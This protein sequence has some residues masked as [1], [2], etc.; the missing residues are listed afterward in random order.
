[1][2]VRT[3][4]LLILASLLLGA[5]SSLPQRP[6]PASEYALSLPTGSDIPSFRRNQGVL[7]VETGAAGPGLE[8]KR[9]AYRQGP[10]ELRYYAR[11]QWAAA[12]SE[13]LRPAIVQALDRSELFRN[14]V[15]QD[16]YVASDYRL[17]VQLLELV[18]DFTAQPSQ[19]Q[20]TLRA[21]LSD[22]DSGEVLGTRRIEAAVPARSEDAVGGVAAAN[23]AVGEALAELVRFIAERLNAAPAPAD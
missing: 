15:P 22:V 5:C 8:T 19:A 23:A 18:Q 6:Q 12:P 4:A 21:Q 9:M 2:T 13:L 1:M 11:S 7:V 14:V 3:T 17:E 20:L 16:G 10:Y